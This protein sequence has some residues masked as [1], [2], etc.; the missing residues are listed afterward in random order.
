LTDNTPVAIITVVAYRWRSGDN[1]KRRI[2]PV[3]YCANNAP[4]LIN[5]SQP[6]SL[7]LTRFRPASASCFSFLYVFLDPL[8][9]VFFSISLCV[10]LH[11]FLSLFSVF[12]HSSLFPFLYLSMSLPLCLCFSFPPLSFLSPGIQI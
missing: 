2:Q 11:F 5:F 3:K 9:L 6:V 10:F 12:L 4:D 1:E 8:F 7:L